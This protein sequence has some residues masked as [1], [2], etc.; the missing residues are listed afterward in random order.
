MSQVLIW[1]NYVCSIHIYIRQCSGESISDV[2][3]ALAHDATGRAHCTSRQAVNERY[4]LAFKVAD[5]PNDLT[6]QPFILPY[7]Y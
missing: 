6:S 4:A 5:A 3:G 7:A 1:M 2:A